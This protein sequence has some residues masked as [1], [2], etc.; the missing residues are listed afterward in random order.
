[1]LSQTVDSVFLHK[2]F[3]I[4]SQIVYSVAALDSYCL[5]RLTVFSYIND[6]QYCFR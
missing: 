3:A 5:R 4:L 6:L 2:W 1:V